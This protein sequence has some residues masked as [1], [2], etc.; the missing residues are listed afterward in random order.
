MADIHFANNLSYL[1]VPFL[2]S[3]QYFSKVIIIII[4][5]FTCLGCAFCALF[6]K[7]GP[8]LILW[9]FSLIFCTIYLIA[10]PWIN[11]FVYDVMKRVETDFFSMQILIYFSTISW[12]DFSPIEFPCYLCQNQLFQFKTYNPWI[13]YI[14]TF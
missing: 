2:F 14:F 3:K 12:K 5:F 6:K 1:W 8:S 7:Y 10:L 9:I 13:F 11:S 4:I